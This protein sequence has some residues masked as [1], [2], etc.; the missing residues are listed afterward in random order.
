MARKRVQIDNTNEWRRSG[1]KYKKK[2]K[3]EKKTGEDSG[4]QRAG[5]Q[6]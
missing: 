2:K 3:K 4:G 1:A 5:P 6:Q